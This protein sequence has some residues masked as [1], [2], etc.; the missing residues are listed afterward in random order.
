VLR[1]LRYCVRAATSNAV[2]ST[3]AVTTFSWENNSVYMW[4]KRPW[5]TA[6]AAWRST[7]SVGRCLKRSTP[8]PEETAPEDTSSNLCP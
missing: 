7:T 5:P 4:N 8:I 2:N 1:A 6:A 3:W